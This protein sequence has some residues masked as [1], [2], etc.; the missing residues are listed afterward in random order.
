[1]LRRAATSLLSRPGA[2]LRA[3]YTTLSQGER[4]M[5][6]ELHVSR[7]SGDPLCM[8]SLC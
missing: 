2:A 8:F 5:A 7:L 3:A 1:M 4:P 6:L